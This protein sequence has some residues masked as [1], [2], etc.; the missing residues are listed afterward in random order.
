MSNMNDPLLHFLAWCVLGID[1][2]ILAGSLALASFLIA[3]H[4]EPGAFWRSI[5]EAHA[6]RASPAIAEDFTSV[7]VAYDADVREGDV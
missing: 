7:G 1:M 4:Y 6:A 5:K 3:C 2:L